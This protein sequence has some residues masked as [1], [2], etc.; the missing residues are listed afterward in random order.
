MRKEEIVPYLQFAKQQQTDVA[1]NRRWRHK[2]LLSNTADKERIWFSTKQDEGSIYKRCP[3]KKKNPSE[4][5]KKPSIMGSW[6]P[7]IEVK[8]LGPIVLSKFGP[9]ELTMWDQDKPRQR[10][11]KRR[12]LT[13]LPPPS[14]TSSRLFE[15][16]T[17][18][19]VSPPLT[20]PPSDGCHRLRLRSEP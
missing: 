11:Y 12:P 20:T 14:P 13:R 17:H 10:L 3:S 15:L 7:W 8:L 4:L 19:L 6:R 1:L 5:R 9:L 2:I 18:Y 16:I